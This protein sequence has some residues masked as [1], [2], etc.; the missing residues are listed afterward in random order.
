MRS[1]ALQALWPVLICAVLWGSAFPC[2][3]IVYQGWQARGLAISIPLV[4]LFAGVRFSLAGLG[5]IAVSRHLRRDLARTPWKYIAGL[6]LTQ[7]V[8]QYVCFYNAIAVSSASLA[9]LLVAT[10]SFWWMFWAAVFR[11][12]SWPSTRQWLALTV[13]AFG[14][15]LAVYR[16]GAGSGNAWLGAGLQLMATCSGAFAVLIFRKIQPTMSSRAATGLSLF[17]GGLV[18]MLL[19]I[20]AL[21]QA[22]EMFDST[23]IL[24]TLWLAFVSATGF[25]LW[26]FIS[27]LYPVPLLASYRFLVPVFGVIEA[28]IFLASESIGWGLIVGG[29]IVI[30]S[31]VCAQRLATAPPPAMKKML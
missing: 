10:G 4:L 19:G 30:A 12:T 8:L 27:T 1:V 15:A 17:S 6:A 11:Q 23:V 22:G 25:A 13:G 18:L 26:N 29:I 7:T 24:I 21:P 5:L 28:Q 16:P 2:I 31:M 14:V 9:A 20:S 3:K